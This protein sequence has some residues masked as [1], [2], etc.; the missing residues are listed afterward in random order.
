MSAA[1]VTWRFAGESAGSG[2]GER[3]YVRRTPRRD[4]RGAVA[5]GCAASRR[6]GGG[7]A[8]RGAGPRGPGACCRR[9][10]PYGSAAAGPLS[11]PAAA[12]TPGRTPGLRAG[13]SDSGRGVSAPGRHPRCR[14]GTWDSSPAPGIPARPAGFQA[15]VVDS[16]PTFESPR[17]FMEFRSVSRKCDPR[18]CEVPHFRGGR[19][20]L[21]WRPARPANIVFRKSWRRGQDSNLRGLVSPTFE[22]CSPVP[23]RPLRAPLLVAAQ[24]DR[25]RRGQDSNLRGPADPTFEACSPVPDQPLRAPLLDPGSR[26]PVPFTRT[27]VADVS[28]GA[29]TPP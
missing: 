17:G 21:T 19:R 23:D 10:G 16:T 9:R 20:V 12:R 28:D 15:G 14:V 13:R 29:L 1:T 3:P 22:T 26:F 25:S 6:D 11:G 7:P 27:T 18:R 5:P 4:R 8:V 2:M 24:V